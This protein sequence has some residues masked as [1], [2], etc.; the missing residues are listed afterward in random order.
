[1]NVHLSLPVER[2]V[3]TQVIRVRNRDKPWFNDDCWLA[4]DIKQEAHLR[5]SRDRSRVKMSLTIARGG[6]MMYMPR[7]CVSLP[8]SRLCSAQVRIRLFLLLLGWVVVWSAHFDGKL[9]R[10]PVDLP[11]PCHPSPSLTTFAFKSRVVKRL[12]LYLDS[13]GGTDILGMFPLFLKKTA[14]VLAH[15]LA[16]AFRPLLRLGSIP[17]CWRV[18]IC[19]PNS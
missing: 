3:L 8:W 19:Q 16:V 17:V 4:F 6:P 5:W 11:S 12:L 7:L 10:D 15:R 9:S 2:F 1:M 13:Y 18:A 14:V